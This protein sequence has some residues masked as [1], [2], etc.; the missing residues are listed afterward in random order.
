MHPPWVDVGGESL[1]NVWKVVPTSPRAAN[2]EHMT[3]EDAVETVVRE[4]F[5]GDYALS[6][7]DIVTR[8]NSGDS[9]FSRFLFGK[10]ADNAR[11]PSRLIR[12]LFSPEGI[13]NLLDRAERQPRWNDRRHRLIRANLSGRRDL[14]PERQWSR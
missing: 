4:C 13:R 11:Y 8:L 5:W 6:V 12:V 1:Q 7:S 9:E 10:I 14:V 2:G 3:K